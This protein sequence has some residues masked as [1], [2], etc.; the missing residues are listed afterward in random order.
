[1]K[2]IKYTELRNLLIHKITQFKANNL[3]FFQCLVSNIVTKTTFEKKL[4]LLFDI[5]SNF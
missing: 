3:E 2:N 1:M 4:E 5:F